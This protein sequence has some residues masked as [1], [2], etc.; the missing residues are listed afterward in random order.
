MSDS[1]KTNECGTMDKCAGCAS[2][3]KG[4]MI[5]PTHRLNKIKHVIAV[6]SGK[7]GVGKSSVTSMLACAFKDAGYKVGIL[8][9]DITGPS[10]PTAFGIQE[11]VYGT[12]DGII[13]ATSKHGIK[14]MSVN[15]ILDDHEQPVL[16][17]GPVVGNMVTQFWTDV[18]WEEI[19]YLFVDMPPGTGDVPLTVFQSIP[20][21][22]AIV[23]SSSQDLVHMIVS[24]ALNMANQMNIEVLGLI[25]NM[26]YFV[27]PDCGNKH[28]IFGESKIQ[29]IADKFHVPVL[30]QLPLD[31]R[32]AKL[33]DEGKI[34]DLADNPLKD[35]IEKI[36]SKNA[37]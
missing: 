7:G 37:E 13:P 10:I 33:C 4:Q 5:K 3:K 12:E 21:T 8:D 25:E 35:I 28:Y 31:A 1:C 19:D 17:R 18:I 24:K 29:D 26:S 14:I 9:A 22:G 20:V 27:C 36:I 15:L 23:V 16:W 32:I 11:P 2:N 30:K 6:C 34:E